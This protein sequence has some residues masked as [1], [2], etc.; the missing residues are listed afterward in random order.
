MQKHTLEHDKK[1]FW[2]FFG[3]VI[4][5]QEI[6][7]ERLEGLTAMVNR[8]HAERL[9]GLYVG[10]EGDSLSIPSETITAEYCTTVI[11]A[12]EAELALA[13]AEK[14]RTPTEEE[15]QTQRWFLAISENPE[16][17]RFVYSKGSLDK[18]T[19]FG[20]ARIW[21]TWLKEQFSLIEA[22]NRRQLERELERSRS[23][24]DQG[25]KN[26]WKIRIRIISQSHAVR[27]KPLNNFNSKIDWIKL[28]AVP[29][30]PNQMIVEFIFKENIPINALWWFGWGVARSFV[31][32]LNIATMGFWW[33]HLPEHI[34][35]YYES[36][37]DI[38]TK[39]RISIARTPSLKVDWGANRRLTDE[40]ML[41][42]ALTLVSLP[43][44]SATKEEQQPFG[45][46]IGGLTFLAINDVNWQCEL[47]SF[48]NLFEGL[49]GFM[50]KFGDFKAG[51]DSLSAVERIIDEMIPSLRHYSKLVEILPAF[52]M[53]NPAGITVTLSEV[54][55]MKI[56][57]DTYYQYRALKRFAAEQTADSGSSTADAPA[58]PL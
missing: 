32:A 25:T 23:V 12:A 17:R 54:A 1:L 38:D 52:A 50:E 40:D 22:E 55:A 11:N 39:A 53:R 33:W 45:Y 7:K 21:V 31:T 41:R 24:P 2:C 35:T 51:G 36:I 9:A 18:L 6:T 8:L 47:Q 48:G 29:S 13:K 57:C 56:L 26:K 49:L 46:Y 42:T 19:E 5:G 10:Y 28:T 44:P 30:K 43:G 16:S 37:E 15:V 58:E 34:D 3:N 27:Q 14:P 20:D 4:N